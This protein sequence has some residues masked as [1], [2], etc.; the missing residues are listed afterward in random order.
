VLDPLEA[1]GRQVVPLEL[2]VLLHGLEGLLGF[3]LVGGQELQDEV[4]VGELLLAVLLLLLGDV[5]VELSQLPQL[6]LVVLDLSVEEET[7]AL[8]LEDAL[9]LLS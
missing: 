9:L 4:V 5:L 7:G 1:D 3:V 8:L 2:G 6:V